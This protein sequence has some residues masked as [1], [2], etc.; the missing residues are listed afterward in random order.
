MET[1]MIR[2]NEQN[3]RLDKFLRKYLNQAPLSFVYKT[4]RKDVKVNGKR[5]NAE[6]LLQPGDEITLYLA[7]EKMAGLHEKKQAPR[8]KKQFRV[9]FESE[10]I[11]V[12]EKPFGLLTHG[13]RHEKKNHLANQVIAYLAQ[14]GDYD[15]SRE[16]T[17]VPAPVNRLDRNTTGL[18][19]FCK[20]YPALQTFNRLI[21]ERGTIQKLYKTILFGDLKEPLHLTAGMIKDEERNM[22]R[23]VEQ[24]EGKD[25]ET[26]VRPLERSGT[27][28]LAEVEILTGRT[29]QIR[30]QL[31]AAG[32]PLIGDAKYGDPGRNRVLKKETGL[33]TQLLHAYKLTFG[34][35]PEEY[36]YLSGRSIE[37]P[38]PPAFRNIQKQLIG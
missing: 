4:I 18:V 19:I 32:Y 28:T 37:C 11:L 20:N 15:P 2:E 35:C 34:E 14:K 6:Y 26:Y 16:R 5:K 8:A 3:Q 25:M 33:S 31:A 36:R 12:V 10:D 17:F 21:R 23:V 13:D 22:V 24:G 30:A 38:V 29:H 1:I 27:Y 9:A 7:P